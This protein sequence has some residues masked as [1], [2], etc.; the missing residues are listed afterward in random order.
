[1]SLCI[2]KYYIPMFTHKL[3]QII[4]QDVFTVCTDSVQNHPNW[5]SPSA[6]AWPILLTKQQLFVERMSECWINQHCLVPR[7]PPTAHLI[8]QSIQRLDGRQVCIPTRYT[9]ECKEAGK[10]ASQG[11]AKR[12][13]WII[14]PSSYSYWFSTSGIAPGNLCFF[15]SSSGDSHI[16]PSWEPLLFGICLQCPLMDFSL[17]SLGIPKKKKR[18]RWS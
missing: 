1:M 14:D 15:K 4:S 7:W 13:G 16:Q 11:R 3:A 8:M 17:T 5:H 12:A 6:I 2:N 9:Q 18:A 10:S